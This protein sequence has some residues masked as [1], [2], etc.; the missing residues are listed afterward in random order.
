MNRLE[1]RIAAIEVAQKRVAEVQIITLH[2]GLPGAP[3]IA[4]AGG[5]YFERGEAEDF[6]TFRTRVIVAAKAA[7]AK[8]VIIGGLPE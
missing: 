7:G 6:E 8:P 1:A 2:G 4:T 3:R 5:V